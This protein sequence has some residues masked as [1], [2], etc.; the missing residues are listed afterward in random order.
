MNM[1]LTNALPLWLAAL[2]LFVGLGCD[3]FLDD[4]SV[5]TDPNRA[6]DVP[7]DQ[8][9]QAIQIQGF[10]MQEGAL[11]RTVTI[12]M[13]QMSGT[14]RQLLAQGQ[15]VHTEADND[16]EMDDMYTGGGLVDFRN[17]MR[18]ASGSG[19]RAYAGMAKF[20]EA[21]TMNTGTQIW[22][23]LPYSEAVR[24]DKLTP[25][26][27]A[28]RDI[29]DALMALLDEAIADFQSGEGR[30]PPN[31][32]VYSGDLAKWIAAAHSLKARIAMHWAEVDPSMY[33]LAMSEA[34]QGISSTDGDF[35]SLHGSGDPES[36]DWYQFY[37]DR[38]T[39]IRSGK[40]LVDLLKSRNDP[41]LSI[42][43]APNADGEFVGSAPGDGNTAASNLSAGYLS[44]AHS[45]DILTFEETILIIAEAAFKTGDEGTALQKLNEARAVLEAKFGMDAGSLPALT[46]LAGD[47]LIDAIAEEMYIALFQ[48]IEV[49]QLWKRTNRPAL[50]PH[51]NLDIPRRMF[52]SQ[53][54]RNANP[55]I[56]APED[57]APRNPNDPGDSY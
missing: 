50:V 56:P 5:T 37:R 20:W 27:D 17:I 26:L 3:A 9:F 36:N 54:E 31:D 41:R 29:D 1:K 8:L 16:D 2:I 55:N 53:D 47:A 42:F 52:Y 44:P 10:F 57:Q 46:G 24:T 35:K 28:M 22:G 15:Y 18:L 23:D 12:W 19:D 43:F 48:N 6:V 45:T 7:I 51:G 11:A 38:D 33:T 30:L 39:Y 14:D 25:K 49:W 40:F 21:L 34:Q 32:Y 4:E 13:Q